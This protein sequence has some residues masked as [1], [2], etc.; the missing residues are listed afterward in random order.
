[1]ADDDAIAFDPLR[2]RDLVVDKSM[3]GARTVAPRAPG[4]VARLVDTTMYYAP[5]SGGVKRFLTEKK[6]WLRKHR[7]SV[8]HTLVV[9]GQYD[10]GDGRGLITVASTRLPFGRG[11]RWPNSKKIWSDRLV[12][13]CPD[14]IEAGD[15]YTPGVAALDAGQRLGVPVVGVCHSDP[16]NSAAL[17]FG[18]WAEKP[19]RRRLERLYRKF[20]KVIAPSRYIADR[21]GDAGVTNIVLQHWGV[22]VDTFSPK[23]RDPAGLRARLG[24]TSR[25]KLLV[26][27]GRPAREKRI[28]VLIEAA[29][30]LGPDYR[31]LLLGA[32]ENC[33]PGPNT[34]VMPY[35]RNAAKLAATIASC[36]LF[37]HANDREMF[38][39]IVLEAMSC[40]LPVV[41]AA[42][43]GVAE[44]I[45]DEVGLSAEPTGWAMAE[46]IRAMF[47]KDL[48]AMGAV[49]RERAVS[50]FTWCNTFE[51]LTSVYAEL[52]GQ[53]VFSSERPRA[54]L[55]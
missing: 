45:D 14:V 2:A 21:L 1:M 33:V 13:L 7:P 55:N 30:R 16:A 22:D 34:I 49:A 5:R 42:G 37:I 48:E 8:A 41:G 19:V 46:A 18:A 10:G 4:D 54:P 52:S 9:P 28:E 6:N 51:R 35:E 39:L 11:Y 3:F 31:L 29:E 47:E 32:G 17:H 12:S 15:P 23:G 40:G 36:D 44:L 50:R 38:G 43:G 26:F 53:P 20:D 25:H 24:L 27:A